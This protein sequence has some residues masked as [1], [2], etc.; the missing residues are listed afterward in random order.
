[1]IFFSKE[2]T[3]HV[4]YRADMYAVADQ[5]MQFHFSWTLSVM[6][7]PYQGADA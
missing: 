2:N 1:M 3:G 4:I 7:R 6:L 5:K